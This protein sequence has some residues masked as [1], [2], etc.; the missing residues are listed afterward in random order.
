MPVIKSTD[1]W[2]YHKNFLLDVDL[3]YLK[4][5]MQDV[6][7]RQ[8]T[9]SK[10]ERTQIVTPRYSWVSGGYLYF[11]N[12]HP[13]WIL[14]LLEYVQA[15]FGER[16]NYILYSKYNSPKHSISPHSDDEFFLGH[17]PKIAILSIGDTVNFELKNKTT[18]EKLI[19][20][21]ESND[22]ILMKDNCQKIF[23]HSIPKDKTFINKTRYSLSFRKVIHPYGDK[24]YNFYN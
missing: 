13:L 2:E 6:P 14:P 21:F 7:W 23:T 12:K 11:N 3:K 15:C 1:S 16:F 19:F 17:K 8:V 18:K 10:K 4:E 5:K 9:Y 24:N 20:S 22:L